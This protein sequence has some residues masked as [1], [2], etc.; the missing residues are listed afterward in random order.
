[1][2]TILKFC[3]VSALALL[4]RAVVRRYSPKVVMVSGSVGKTSTKDAVAAVLGTRFFVRKS[5]KS[6][7]SEFGVPFTIL[8][9][10]NPWNNPLA[11]L[12]VVKSA[13]ALILLPNQ[14]PNMLVLEVGAD[15]P[16]DLARILRIATPNVVVMTRTP[17][18]PVHVE[19]YASP[20]AV[21]EEEFS[22]A[23]A[24]A[25]AAPLVVPADDA[26]A[27]DSALR[28]P[29]RV[30]S[31]GFAEDASVR[32]SDSDFYEERGRVIGMQAKVCAAGER[33]TCVVK[34][35]AGRVQLLP[36]AAALA[37]AH[38]FSIPLVDALAALEGYEPPPGRGRIFAGKND[39]VVV[40]D[41]YNASPAA[42]EEA[43]AMLK[44]FPHAKR[45]IA[46]LGDMLELGRYSVMEHERIGALARDAADVIAAV[47]I[48]ARALASVAG[49][50]EVLLFDNSRDAA[51]A[52]VGYV[53]RGDVVLVKGSQSIRTEHIVKA[54][55][56]DPSDTTRL[57]RQEKKWINKS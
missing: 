24:L 10:E 34:G 18:I 17:K 50:R 31:Y 5:E 41:S 55:L 14:Y 26:Y 32:I 13:L 33:G 57:A 56:A 9:A 21:W 51:S 29:A 20:E 48:R 2:K 35:S 19:A 25:A 37:T 22:P 12:S 44:S 15:R 1:M 52:L 23:Y 47:G 4:S 39:S 16:G 36:V 49:N 54:L 8:G 28:M 38:A 53:R 46:V 3:V 30:I 27:L 45:R 40:D 7:N 11:W 43:L 6:F 42:V